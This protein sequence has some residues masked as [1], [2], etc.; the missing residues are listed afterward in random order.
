MLFISMFYILSL[1]WL[2]FQA[3]LLLSKISNKNN[4]VGD[5]IEKQRLYDAIDCLLSFVVRVL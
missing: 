3:V 5:P 4:L 2:Y 1:L